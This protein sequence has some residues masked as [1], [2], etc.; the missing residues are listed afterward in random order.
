MSDFPTKSYDEVGIHIRDDDW[1]DV[2]N[3]M[4]HA[5]AMCLSEI[6]EGM[7]IFPT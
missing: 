7:K 2:V 3:K 5:V 6:T 4:V 1:L